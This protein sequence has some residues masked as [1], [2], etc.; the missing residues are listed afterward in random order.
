MKI[1]EKFVIDTNILIYSL[2]KNSLFFDFSKNLILQNKDNICIANKTI[3]E[4]V[5]VFSKLGKYEIIQNE[6]ENII[7]TFSIIYSNEKSSNHFKNLVLKY[8]PLG[9]Q[10]YDYE[11]VSVMMA[12][13][14]KK[15]VTINTIDYKKIKEI[16][17]I[18]QPTKPPQSKPK[19]SEK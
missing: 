19:D 7:E 1:N 2:D 14:I 8:K 16:E 3:P 12:N 9:N 4:F 10:A 11:I 13:N 6:L 5:C 17:I 15:L 18:S